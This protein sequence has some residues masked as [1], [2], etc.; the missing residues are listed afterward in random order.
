MV[1][2]NVTCSVNYNLLQAAKKRNIV[3][4]NVLEKGLEIETALSNGLEQNTIKKLIQEND[5]KTNILKLRLKELDMRLEK[6]DELAKV[7]IIGE[8]V[9]IVRMNPEL[10]DGRLRLLQNKGIDISKFEFKKILKL[11]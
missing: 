3:V 8:S 4:S 5:N 7:P 10:F 11:E 1:K 9:K 6:I 2:V